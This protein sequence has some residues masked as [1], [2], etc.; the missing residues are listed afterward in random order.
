MKKEV[1]YMNF[2]EAMKEVYEGKK[3]RLIDWNYDR[4]VYKNKLGDLV[5]DNGEVYD[6]EWDFNLYD[7]EWELYK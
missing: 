2:L 4:Y 7:R 5:W 6:R 1:L 3:V